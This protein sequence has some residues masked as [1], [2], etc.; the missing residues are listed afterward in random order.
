[1]QNLPHALARLATFPRM[2]E[3]LCSTLPIDDLRRKPSASDWSILEILCHLADEE[4]SDFRPRVERTL[5]GLPWDPIDPQG[6]AVERKYNEQSPAE[7]IAR[8]AAERERSIA[9][10]TSLE[11][12]DWDAV[13]S[14]PKFGPIRAGDI[15]ASWLAHDALHL[16]QIAK[17]LYELAQRDGHPHSTIYAGSW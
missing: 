8:F 1:M 15:M 11:E 9:W 7:V 16:R 14:H 5:G 3:S 6:W 2:L 4:T 17:R 10:L 13:H 12:P